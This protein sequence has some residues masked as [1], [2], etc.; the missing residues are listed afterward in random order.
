MVYLLIVNARLRRAHQPGSKEY[1]AACKRMQLFHD[2]TH[3]KD[4]GKI[5]KMI[6][7]NR[8]TGLRPGDSRY[9]FKCDKCYRVVGTVQRKHTSVEQGKARAPDNLRPGEKWLVDGGDATVRSKWGSYRYFLLFVCAK[10]S[11]IIIY[12]LKDNSARSYVAALK[13]VDRLVRLRKGYGVKTLYG[14]FFSTHLD[15]NV[16]GALRADLG[17]EFEVTPP[18]MH[19]LNGYAEVYMRVMK[20][21]TRVRLLQMIGKY[22]DDVRITDST[23]MWPFAMEHA[24]QSKCAE[25]STTIE[26]DTGT[27]ATREQMFREDTETPIKFH[28]HPFGTRCYVIIQKSQRYSAMTDTAEACLYLMGAG[29]NPFSHTFVDASQAHIVLRS[30]NRLQITGRVIFPYMKGD[31][32]PPSDSTSAAPAPFT[33][34]VGDPQIP[35]AVQASEQNAP[36][37]LPLEPQFRTWPSAPSPLRQL[38]SV[39]DRWNRRDSPGHGG[40]APVLQ[41]ADPFAST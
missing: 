13:Y 3:I 20:I 14:D 31:P 19:W 16:L 6:V 39:F 32:D 26:K 23:D 37:G 30:G 34:S 38:P 9:P 7:T 40:I 2:K 41:P 12:Y 21:A 1:E 17:I 18:Y 15:Q 24:R 8:E 36:A 28:L 11:Y 5:E 4:A 22:L 35:A 29:Y 10:S 27:F 25:P 33:G